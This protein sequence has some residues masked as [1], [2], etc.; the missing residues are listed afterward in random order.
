MADYFYSFGIGVGSGMA[1]GFVAYAAHIL[2]DFFV[3]V[4]KEVIF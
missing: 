4:L 2:L 1:A 3:S